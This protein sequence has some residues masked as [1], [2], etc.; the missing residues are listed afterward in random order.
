MTSKSLS[1]VQW[2]LDR[3]REIIQLYDTIPGNCQVMDALTEEE[4]QALSLEDYFGVI[5]QLAAQH[6]R[7]I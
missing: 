2:R 6:R 1:A 4:F 3:E 7:L 5:E